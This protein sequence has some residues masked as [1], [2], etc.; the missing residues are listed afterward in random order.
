[1]FGEPKEEL[2]LVVVQS[3]QVCTKLDPIDPYG[4]SL[5]LDDKAFIAMMFEL[6]E[7]VHLAG[8]KI[9]ILLTAGGGAQSTGFPYDRGMEGM[10]TIQNV[11]P[12]DIQSDFSNRPV[13][14][15]T[16]DEIGKI[17]K[18]FGLA[19]GRAKQA[20]FDAITIHG[21][22]GYLISQFISPYMNNRNDKYGG[23]FDRRLRFLLELIESCT[24]NAGADFPLIFRISI[25]ECIPK[26][27]DIE[28]SIRICKSLEE[29][30][31]SAIDVCVGTSQVADMIYPIDI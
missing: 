29:V 25:D 12:G 31:V 6:T 5:R 7:A 19:A 18:L 22:G 16:I 4:P 24:K 28:E 9:S 23:S 2:A 20:G 11:S 15:L 17:I 13:R 1:M 10:A 21:W 14:R 3:T 27:R 8:S 30:G 26:G